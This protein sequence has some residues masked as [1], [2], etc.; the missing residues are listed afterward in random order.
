MIVLDTHAWVWLATGSSKLTKR[1]TAAC[2]KADV[3][4]VP[5]ISV[6]E[7]AMLVSKGRLGLDRDVEIWVQQALSF[8][9]IRLEPLLPSI[10]V[11]ST[12]LPGDFHGDPADRLIAA[13]ALEH[14]IPL[15][16]K[17]R[18]LSKYPQLRTV[19]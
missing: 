17:D 18:R 12:R 5:A 9:G 11:R 19:W 7:V 6:W 8:P 4:L 3:M 14:G 2:R 13:T 16:T 1:A 10:C 15:I